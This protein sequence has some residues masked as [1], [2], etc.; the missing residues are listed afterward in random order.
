MYMKK[1]LVILLLSFLASF[2]AN[3]GTDGE[4]SISKKTS[5]LKIVLKAYIEEYL[6]LIKA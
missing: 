6:L 2:N 5:Q 4:N 3:A 1:I